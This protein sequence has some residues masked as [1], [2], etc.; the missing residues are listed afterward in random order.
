MRRL[1]LALLLLAPVAA[2][3]PIRLQHQAR[4]LDPAGGPLEGAFDVVVALHDSPTGSAFWTEALA[5]LPVDGGYV[6]VALGTSPGNPL[7]HTALLRPAVYLSLAID[8]AELGPRTLLHQVPYAAVATWAATAG[9]AETV[10]G[11]GP[12]ALIPSGAILMFE[13]ACPAGFVEHSAMAGRMP[14][15]ASSTYAPGATGGADTHV[16]SGTIGATD[17][18]HTHNLQIRGLNLG[19]QDVWAAGSLGGLEGKV[20]FGD[21]STKLDCTGGG[22]HHHCIGGAH[23]DYLT[24]TGASAN[25]SHSH[26]LSVGSA[27]SLPPYRAVRFC[28]KS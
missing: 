6:S 5:D 9:D 23:F 19:A 24:T 3:T 4:L 27:S 16:H 21:D 11:I 28:R 14:I 13:G 22:V 8:G 12:D 10:G 17:L 26:T 18:S 20:L 2:A 15:G 7:D 1:P 25:L